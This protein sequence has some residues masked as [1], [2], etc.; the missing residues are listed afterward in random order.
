MCIKSLPVYYIQPLAS[1]N[2][3]IV[4]Y[5]YSLLCGIQNIVKKK[6]FKN[7]AAPVLQQ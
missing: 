3:N 5:V 2:N 7:K 1:K 6:I 4:R